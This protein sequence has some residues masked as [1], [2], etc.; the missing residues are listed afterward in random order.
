MGLFDSLFGIDSA[1]NNI[2]S[3]GKKATKSLQDSYTDVQGMYS[4]YVQGGNQAYGNLLALSGAG[5]PQAAQGAVND[6]QSSPFATAGLQQGV[7]AINRASPGRATG[8]VLRSLMDYGNDNWWRNFDSYY[9]RQAGIA[10]TGV[11]ATGATAN[12]R[13]NM[14]TGVAGIQQNVG[15][16]MANADLAS[17]SLLSGLLNSGIGA[18]AYMYG[19]S[20]G[21]PTSAP[22][23]GSQ[24]WTYDNYIFGRR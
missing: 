20:F 21:V 22:A 12:A 17:G 2:K 6:F 19:K 15:N 5:G 3:A 9:N 7:D 8:N 14:G 10:N 24:P 1:R 11:Q 18:G 23:S 4:P 13:Q 16:Q